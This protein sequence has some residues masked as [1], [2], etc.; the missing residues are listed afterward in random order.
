VEQIDEGPTEILG[1]DFKR[2]SR[3]QSEQIGPDAFERLNDGFAD[4]KI[5]TGDGGWTDRKTCEIETCELVG[6]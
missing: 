6:K 4:W 1:I 2:S 5:G 3:E